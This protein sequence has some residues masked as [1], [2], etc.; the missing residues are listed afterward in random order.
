MTMEIKALQDKKQDQDRKIKTLET[1]LTEANIRLTDDETKVSELQDIKLK[2][3]KEVEISL[4]QVEEFD[5]KCSQLER[6]K[7]SLEDQLTETQ[8]CNGMKGRD[9]WKIHK[10]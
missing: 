2:L 6:N 3:Q 4:S 10:W 1:Q 7:K 8:V 5:S 9:E